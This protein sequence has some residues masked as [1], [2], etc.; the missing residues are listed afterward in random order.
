M[1]VASTVPN[2]SYPF[3]VNGVNGGHTTWVQGTLMVSTPP[4]PAPTISAGPANGSLTNQNS[5]SFSFSDSQA[6]VSFLCKLDTGSF[7]AC[8]SP[9]SYSSLGNGSHTFTVEAKDPA[10]N[11]SSG[12][13]SRTWTVDTTPPAAPVLDSYPPNPSTTATSTFTWHDT[14]TDVDHYLCSIENGAFQSTVPSVG[15]SPQPCSSPLTYN[16]PNTNN[17]THQFAV[18]AVDHAGNISS[19]TSYSWKVQK[20]SGINYTIGNNPIAPLIEG[21]A[22]TP[23][24]VTFSNPN[25]DS[26]RDQQHHGQHQ[27]GHRRRQHAERL[28]R[29]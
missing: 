2:G 11:I 17:G 9:A 19:S 16:I 20:N 28:H 18:E 3:A 26:E 8:T 29:R 6:G 22:P 15:G 14:S 12:N 7:T 24:D 13:P 21:A 23:I 10:G 1:A 27:L 5:A 25:S 4:P